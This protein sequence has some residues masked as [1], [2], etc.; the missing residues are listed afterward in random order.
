MSGLLNSSFSNDIAAVLLHSLWQAGLLYLLLKIINPLI[1]KGSAGLKYGL[2]LGALMIFAGTN[3]L[4]LLMVFNE[5]AQGEVEMI[6]AWS[7]LSFAELSKSSIAGNGLTQ[8]LKLLGPYFVLFWWLGLV[9]FTLRFGINM[10]R[11]HQL[12]NSGLIAAPYRIS[13]LFKSLVRSLRMSGEI[14]IA[15]SEMVLSPA[16]I[17]FIKPIVLLPVGLVNGLSTDEVEAILIHELSHIRR[18]DYLV[19]I[20]QS[21]V[22]VIY[23]FN[24]F[25]WLISNVIRAEREHV[26][27]DRAI[28]SGIPRR[29]YAEI[30]ANIYEHAYNNNNLAVSFADRNKL[31]LKRI[32]RI[33]KTQSNNNRLISSLLLVLAVSTAIYLGAEKHTP[34]SYMEDFSP[35]RIA[36]ASPLGS[37]TM[38]DAHDLIADL[39]RKLE[40]P[41]TIVKPIVLPDTIDEKEIKRKAREYEEAKARLESTKEWK[42]LEAIREEMFE[43]QLEVMKE[44]APQV[45]EALKA[46]EFEIEIDEVELEALQEIMAEMEFELQEVEI[47][48]EVVRAME[49]SSRIIE[50]SMA[51]VEVQLQAI[52]MVEFEKMAREYEELAR[53]YAMEAEE[54][55]MQAEKASAEAMKIARKVESFM[56][57]LKPELIKDGY[58]KNKEDLDDLDF[59]DGKVYVNKKEVSAKHA[60]KYYEIRKKHLGE[61][62]EFFTN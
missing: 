17:G 8:Q 46:V 53:N 1:N 11:T 26:C 30:L 23:F 9:I 60:K 5:P 57:E 55:A 37:V 24:P 28:A 32:R 18:H 56:D 21:M 40:T 62:T 31:T 27:D 2:S 25:V 20:M 45:E 39:K 43:K 13:K 22:E 38:S 16:V 15:L 41:K 58:I 61:N 10:Y 12:A 52:Q 42:E 6:A 44:I 50:E 54:I 33:M 19:N 59:E 51:Q 47:N 36:V 7:N 35:E 14:R 3:L 48:E 29:A 34:A 49:Q 4:T